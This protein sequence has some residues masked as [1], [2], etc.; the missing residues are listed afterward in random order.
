MTYGWAI[1]IIAVVLVALFSI[2]IFKTSLPSTCIPES[3]F[4]CTDMIFSANTMNPHNDPTITINLGYTFSEQ[5]NNVYFVVVPQGQQI[6]DTNIGDLSNPDDFYYWAS[7]AGYAA[8]TSSLSPGQTFTAVIYINPNY[9]WLGAPKQV[10]IGDKFE[11]A[12]WAMYNV[13]G[14]STP[15]LAEVG[16]FTAVATSN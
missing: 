8:H 11:G 7:T 1:L 9:P 5:W 12:I 2:G 3:G 15:L 4:M 6:S 14:S 10:T 16:S 13:P